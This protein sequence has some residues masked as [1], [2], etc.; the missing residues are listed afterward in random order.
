MGRLESSNSISAKRLSH[1]FVS[2]HAVMD[3][4]F[5]NSQWHL[6]SVKLGSEY[7]SK[8]VGLGCVFYSIICYLLEGN[9]EVHILRHMDHITIRFLPHV[10]IGES[11]FISR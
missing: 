7:R 5:H 3:S 8:C 9:V 2:T 11:T 10:R 6:N 1:A 4:L